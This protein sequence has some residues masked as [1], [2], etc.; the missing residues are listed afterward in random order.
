MLLEDETAK[1]SRVVISRDSNEV[2]RLACGENQ[3]YATYYNLVEAGVRVPTAS[4]YDVNRPA[5]DATM[6][7]YYHPQIRFGALTL[8]DRGLGHYG[9]CHLILKTDMVDFRTTTFT[10]NSA[11]FVLRN[12]SLLP[13]HRATWAHRGRLAVAKLVSVLTPSSTGADLPAILTSDGATPDD[14]VFIEAHVYGSISM[15]TVEKVIV[16]R[17]KMRSVKLSALK[18]KLKKMGVPLVSL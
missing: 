4:K 12:G 7:P 3:L 14:D 1:R 17:T 6:F 13:G 15:R 9:D 8:D 10:E 2:Y 5:I 16:T 18:D 11:A